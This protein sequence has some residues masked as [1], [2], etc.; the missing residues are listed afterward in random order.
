MRDKPEHRR[1]S[2]VTLLGMPEHIFIVQEHANG[3]YTLRGI[4]GMP[5]ISARADQVLAVPKAPRKG[6]AAARRLMDNLRKPKKT[7]A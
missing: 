1:K 2:R 3:T 6:E 7:T 5:T 4:D